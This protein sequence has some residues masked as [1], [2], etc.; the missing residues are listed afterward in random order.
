MR[1]NVQWGV[2]FVGWLCAIWFLRFAPEQWDFI[3]NSTG[4]QETGCLQRHWG[5]DAA[6]GS[7]AWSP[8]EY[9]QIPDS[10]IYRN[11]GWE[12]IIFSKL[13]FSHPAGKLQNDWKTRYHSARSTIT[14]HIDILRVCNPELCRGHLYWRHPKT[15]KPGFAS[16]FVEM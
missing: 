2:L 9:S 10:P 7:P 6:Q 12:H 4:N 5:D 16:S 8:G 1:T 14:L 13:M 11:V 3:T 15:I